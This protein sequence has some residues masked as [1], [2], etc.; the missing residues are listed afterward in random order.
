M[1]KIPA[2]PEPYL[3]MMKKLLGAE[4]EDYLN[5]FRAEKTAGLRVNTLKISPSKFEQISPFPLRRVPWTENGYYI[6][7]SERAG[8]HPYYFAGLYYLQEPSAMAPAQ[9]LPVKP[10]ERVL[11][12]C[13]APG[14]KSTELAA[15]LQG[16]GL[17]VSND[18]SNS[19]AQALL[20]N[21]ELFGVKNAL[22][23]SEDPRNLA[24]RFP[25]YFDKILIDAPCSGQGMFRKDPAVIRSYVE[26][27]IGFYTALQKSITENALRMLRPGGMLLYST[28]TFSV[29]E[30]EEIVLHMKKCC[31]GL[32][33][34]DFS[35]RYE[36]F[37]LGRPD[38]ASEDDP[39]LLFCARLYPHKLR[40]EG[41]FI[42][43]LQK[44]GYPE[45]DAVQTRKDPVRSR[46]SPKL[47]AETE[48]FLSALGMPP[49]RD[50]LELRGERLYL[51]PKGADLPL[52]GLRIL[53]SGLLL[54]EQK[55][56]R[57]EPSQALAMALR[58]EEYP[59]CLDLPV[60][61]ERVI[62]YLKGETLDITDLSPEENGRA[63]LCT[64]GYPL[65]FGKITGNMLKNGYL[66]GWRYQ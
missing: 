26:H 12:L 51:A 21:L 7:A 50:R 57:F 3:S 40:G 10:G 19:R 59:C 38:L 33:V 27:G 35:G 46:T 6:G 36:G 16:E 47:S 44:E 8:K 13:A 37:S 63:L 31:P 5:S 60:Q 22:I 34:A 14:G 29:E 2:L 18:I 48:A 61:D 49:D 4:Y 53:R 58:K 17:L 25:E 55:K 9:I 24:D 28:C 23:L 39:E 1:N 66:P 41:H 15:K 45:E 54:G 20:K 56:G 64:D 30:D 42:A 65:G 52:T 11:D 32:H 62:R 43:L